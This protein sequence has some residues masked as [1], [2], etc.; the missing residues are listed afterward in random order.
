MASTTNEDIDEAMQAIAEEVLTLLQVRDE[1]QA[2]KRITE[3]G[4]LK[5][6]AAEMAVGDLVAQPS[7]ARAIASYRERHATEDSN[8]S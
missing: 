4:T 8:G 6:K 3:R 2:L 7:V 5:G 1:C